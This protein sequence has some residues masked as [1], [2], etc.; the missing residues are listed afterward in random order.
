MTGAPSGCYLSSMEANSHLLNKVVILQGCREVGLTTHLP[1]FSQVV[2][3]HVQGIDSDGGGYDKQAD[4]DV[5]QNN[6]SFTSRK[7]GRYNLSD[8]TNVKPQLIRP[9][10]DYITNSNTEKTAYNDMG[11]AQWVSGQLYNIIQLEDLTLVKQMLQVT[12]SIRDAVAII[13]LALRAAWE[14]SMTQLEEGYLHWSN[15]TQWL[16]NRTNSF[17]IAVLSGQV[18]GISSHR[19]WLCR[20]YNEGSCS[21]KCH[22]GAHCHFC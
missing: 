7:S 12:I 15:H 20:F 1:C 18:V 3:W 6:C 9:N 2:H 22:H 8:T 11:M 5:L 21:R 14:V 17:Q 4:M 10:G 13:W 16:L 19:T